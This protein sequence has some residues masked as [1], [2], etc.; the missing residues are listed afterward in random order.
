[1]QNSDFCILHAEFCCYGVHVV[2]SVDDG[3]EQADTSTFP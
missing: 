3:A 1:M 2:G